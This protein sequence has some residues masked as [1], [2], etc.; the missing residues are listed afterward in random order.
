MA[1]DR[2]GRTVHLWASVQP[3][4]DGATGY[5]RDA[6]AEDL[7]AALQQ[8]D[9]LRAQVLLA[10]LPSAEEMA[11]VIQARMDGV[12]G[13]NLPVSSLSMILAGAVRV[14]LGVTE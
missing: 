9:A 4:H 11:R 8:N 3:E 7:I 1:F 13:T 12:A 2:D 6:D 5:Q 14:A 10:V